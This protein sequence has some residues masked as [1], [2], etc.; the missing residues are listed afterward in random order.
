MRMHDPGSAPA[1]VR[2]DVDAAVPGVTAARVGADR[3]L[4]EIPE[5][6]CLPSRRR[7]ARLEPADV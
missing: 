4:F 1:F 3:F 5:E 2:G 7:D 6:T